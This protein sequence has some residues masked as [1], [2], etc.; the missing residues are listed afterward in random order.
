MW[1]KDDEYYILRYLRRYN[2]NIS[3]CQIHE[4]DHPRIKIRLK[5]KGRCMQTWI[6]LQ[7]A[8]VKFAETQK[9]KLEEIKNE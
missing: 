3:A 5:S 9:E 7:R 4:K 6:I 8:F 2:D 1:R